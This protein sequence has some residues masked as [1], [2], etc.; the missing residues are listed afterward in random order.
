MVHVDLEKMSSQ[1]VYYFSYIDQCNK[2]PLKY[3]FFHF[4]KKSICNSTCKFVY[5]CTC[6]QEEEIHKCTCKQ[7]E[8]IH[9]VFIA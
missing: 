3:F 2:F 8:E 9:T 6:K 4:L 1:K 7:E 5:T